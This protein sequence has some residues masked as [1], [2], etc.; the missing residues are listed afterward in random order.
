MAAGGAATGGAAAGGG[1]AGGAGAG[2]RSM[3]AVLGHDAVRDA[4]RVSVAADRLPHAL[5]FTGPEGVGKRTLA[6]AFARELLAGAD[7][8]EQARFDRGALDRFLL[9][10]DLERAL[11]V[12]RGDLLG[13]NLDEGA[14][15]EAYAAL[16]GEGWLTG[17]AEARG[18]DVIDL[19]QRNAEKFTGRKGIPFADVLER[20]LAQL[21]RAKK[22]TAAS[23]D[24]A[25]RLFSPGTS[26]APYRR[27][28]GIDLIN[29]KGDGEY[30]RTVETMLRNAAAGPRV[31]VLD[32]AHRMTD[33]AENAFLKTLEEPPAGALLILVT[34]EPLSLLSTTVSRC[35]RVPF[36]SVPP[37]RLA[38][39]LAGTQGVAKADAPLFA[40]LSGGSVRRALELR[41]LDLRARASFVERILEAVAA[42]DLERTLAMAGGRFSEVARGKGRNAERDEA[43]VL[44]EL[45]ALA[46]RDLAVS[47]AAPDVAPVSGL[48][49]Q[50]VAA[51]AARRSA[52]RWERLFARTETA[53]SDVEASVEPRLAVEALFAD[54]LPA[55][56]VGMRW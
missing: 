12:R 4:L 42:G 8:A 23:V 18:A 17:V 26:R 51:L 29:G 46:F 31:V 1:A 37:D 44:L 25:R 33:A 24:V 27:S 9:Y 55:P 20:E 10:E 11:A 39:F 50:A 45:L 38:A 47:C 34:S 35:A 52:P 19:L 5:L 54:A 30:F 13:G 53:L 16:E 56:A 43:R 32:D 6:V 40:S 14:L 36:D 21:G 3:D 2:P 15:L 28:I 7:P 41:G 48:D 22:A 49:P